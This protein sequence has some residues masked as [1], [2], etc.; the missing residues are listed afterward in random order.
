MAFLDAELRPGIDVVM[1]AA[2]VVERLPG[3]GLVVTGEGKLDAQSLHGKTVAGVHRAAEEAGIRVLVV[4]GQA[5]IRP[6]GV[7]VESLA[8]AF[9]IDR[10][11]RDTRAALEELVADVARRWPA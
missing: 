8:D 11:L 7:R 9:G 2:R 1:E 10:A 6:D 3:A 4:C 5:T